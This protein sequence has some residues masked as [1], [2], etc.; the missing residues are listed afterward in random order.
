MLENMW[1]GCKKNNFPSPFLYGIPKK[2][3]YFAGRAFEKMDIGTYSGFKNASKSTFNPT[4][5]Y[6]VTTNSLVETDGCNELKGFLVKLNENLVIP[7][8][9]LNINPDGH[10]SYCC[11]QVGDFGDFVNNPVDTL[12]NV[13]RNPVAVMMRRGDT[14]GPFLNLVASMDPSI[15]VFGKG[16]DAAVVGSTCYQMLSGKRKK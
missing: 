16:K 10:L 5:N 8:N 14:V 11:A 3:I 4:K 2:E 13:V 15:K 1:Y 7:C 12:K 9:N 6:K